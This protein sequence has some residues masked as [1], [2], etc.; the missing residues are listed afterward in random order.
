LKKKN[1]LLLFALVLILTFTAIPGCGSGP[2]NPTTSDQQ[3]ISTDSGPNENIQVHGHWTI[4]ILDRDGTLVKRIES[5][6]ALVPT[7]AQTLAS[8]MSG[9]NTIGG[10]AIVVSGAPAPFSVIVEDW[11]PDANDY[12]SDNLTVEAD[13]DMLTLTGSATATQDGDIQ[14]LWTNCGVLPDTP[15]YGT[16]TDFTQV[17]FEPSE[18]SLVAGQQALITVEITFSP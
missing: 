14:H 13:G 7:G 2:S 9:D 18:I 6:N 8:V 10:W 3:S 12:D 16:T 4:E 11:H 17:D 15:P 1:I 5:D